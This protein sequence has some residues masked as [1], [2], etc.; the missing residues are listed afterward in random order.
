MELI[1]MKLLKDTVACEPLL[2]DETTKGGIHIPDSARRHWTHDSVHGGGVAQDSKDIKMGY[3]Q[4]TV[5]AVGEGR[6]TKHGKRIPITL[7]VGDKVIVN[8]IAAMYNRTFRLEDGT[9][10][11]FVHENDCLMA[12]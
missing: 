9:K 5:R 2:P 10:V 4:A 12:F 11:F 7:K 1:K 6:I 3:A 8:R